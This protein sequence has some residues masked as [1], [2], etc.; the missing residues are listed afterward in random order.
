MLGELEAAVTKAMTV[1]DAVAVAATQ[2]KKQYD[3]FK[4]R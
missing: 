1:N 3:T 2:L 4:S